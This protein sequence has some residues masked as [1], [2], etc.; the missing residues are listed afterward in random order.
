MYSQN[1]F[2]ITANLI[3]GKLTNFACDGSLD[4]RVVNLVPTSDLEV[5]QNFTL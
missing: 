1:L 5:S 3:L 2:F 4:E